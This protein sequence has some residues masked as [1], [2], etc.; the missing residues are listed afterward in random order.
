MFANNAMHSIFLVVAVLALIGAIGIY[1]RVTMKGYKAKIFNKE[2]VL[3]NKGQYLISLGLFVVA[4]VS[5]SIQ[6]YTNEYNVNYIVDTLKISIDGWHLFL[7]YF[8]S[9]FFAVAL[10]FFA[11]V[12]II[13]F[14]F[15]N[16]YQAKNKKK[17]LFTLLGS[18]VVLLVSFYCF[19]EGSAPFLR[20][21]FV[22]RLYIGSHGILLVTDYTGYNWAP[23]PTDGWH[24][25]IAFYALC[26][27][28][29][30]LLVLAVCSHQLKVLYGQG[31]LITNLFLIAFPVG[32][33]SCRAW[34]VIG[35]WYRDG[36]DKDFWKIF[37]INE[38]GLAIMGASFAIL[39]GIIY[40]LILKYKN[41]KYP[42]TKMNYLVVIDILVPTIL[43][44]QAVGRWGNFFN[45]EVH[46]NLV[47][48][49]YFM[50]LPTFV[51]NNMHFSNAHQATSLTGALTKLNSG[52]IYLPLFYIESIANLIGYLVIE[53]AFRVGFKKLATPKENEKRKWYQYVS[54]VIS[55]EGNGLSWYLVWYGLTRAILEPL[56][57]K[58]FNMGNDDLW[59][60]YSSYVMI[61]IGLLFV[62]IFTVWQI[63]RDHGKWIL[64][65]KDVPTVSEKN[66]D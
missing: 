43:L 61:A 22:N 17:F 46:G 56:R 11:S 6:F 57:D 20:Y 50:W 63:Q 53:F 59:S 47:N 66:N 33:V 14:F 39:V 29:G 37:R 40:I 10:F 8:G 31:G 15:E 12:F 48:E 24:F 2:Y 5:F 54:Y 34:Y 60:V 35:N 38:G 30:A 49:S 44:A 23:A 51:R 21:P 55:S 19:S 52:E 58:V 13:Y 42:Y 32:I 3:K 9:V 16:C 7:I 18:L 26:I 45:N 28:S 1:Y 27:L 41:K 65:V 36:F 62:V 64:K 25:E 4:F